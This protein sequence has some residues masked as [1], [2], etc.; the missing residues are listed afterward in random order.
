MFGIDGRRTLPAVDGAVPVSSDTVVLIRIVLIYAV[1]FDITK[2]RDIAFQERRKALR[3]LTGS[4]AHE[5]Y[6]LNGIGQRFL[7]YHPDRPAEVLDERADFS[8]RG[9]ET[10]YLFVLFNLLKNAFYYL[11]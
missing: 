6:T 10:L 5:R 9:D 11:K 2:R 1:A 8:F 7:V 3:S 4:I